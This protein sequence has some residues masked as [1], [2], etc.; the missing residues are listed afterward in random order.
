MKNGLLVLTALLLLTACSIER[1]TAL[2][3]PIA[4]FATHDKAGG[5]TT[6]IRLP[7]DEPFHIRSIPDLTLTNLVAIDLSH[8]MTTVH[9]PTGT[10]WTSNRVVNI[11]M[12]DRDARAFERLTGALQDRR[13][14]VRWGPDVI[15][16]PIVRGTIDRGLLQIT[17]DSNNTGII[18]AQVAKHNAEATH[19]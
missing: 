16:A 13:L 19:P 10:V 9:S 8:V 4:F 5:D 17:L 3:E 7:D 12:A 14:A 1:T 11:W 2:A 18:E 15:G 6:E